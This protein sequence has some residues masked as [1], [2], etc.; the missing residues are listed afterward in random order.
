MAQPSTQTAYYDIKNQYDRVVP[1]LIQ[2]ECLV[3][4]LDCKGGGTG[5]VGLTDRRVIFYDQ[6]GLINKT[7]S[8]V[9]IPYNQVIAVSSEDEGTFFKSSTITLITAAGK[10]SFEF[11]GGDKAHRAYVYI[12]NQ[13]LTQ[14]HP[15]LAG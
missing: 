12:M 1:Y 10:F 3:A 2:S 15:Q 6:N 5:F 11:R 9:S 8:M 13:I 7:K 4:V 14:A